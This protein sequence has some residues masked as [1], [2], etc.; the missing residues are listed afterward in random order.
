MLKHALLVST[1][2]YNQQNIGVVVCSPGAKMMANTLLLLRQ[3]GKHLN[4]HVYK[5][6]MLTPKLNSDPDLI[7]TQF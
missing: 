3:T 5:H 6:R 1:L 7:A 4:D 2:V